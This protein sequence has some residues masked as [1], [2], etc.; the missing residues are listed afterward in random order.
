MK[1]AKLFRGLSAVLCLLFFIVN[2]LT[3]GMFKN[4]G[5]INKALNINTSEKV[6]GEGELPIRYG[7]EFSTD[8]NH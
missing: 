2:G 5:F 1:K 6:N 8:I 7:S 4:E 3:V